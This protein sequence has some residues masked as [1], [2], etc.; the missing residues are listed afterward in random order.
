MKIDPRKTG[1]AK[2]IPLRQRVLQI[3]DTLE[4]TGTAQQLFLLARG[5]PQDEFEVHVCVLSHS[6]PLGSE[7]A[8]AGIPV[9]TIGRRWPADPATIWRLTRL[10]KAI[11]PDTIYAWQ[12]MGRA[13]AT[14]AARYCRVRM[15]AVWR[16]AQLRSSLQQREIDGAVGRQAS[17]VVATCS[18]VRDYCIQQ[19]I[20]AEKIRVIPG[21]VR[22]PLPPVATRG[23][24]LNRLGLSE[25]VALI[26]WASRLEA[27]RGGKDAIWAADLLKVIRDDAHL[28]IFGAGPHRDRLIRFRDQV[29]IADKVHFLGARADLDE[30]LPHFDQFWSTRRLPGMPQGIL[31]A[32]AAGTPVV[33]TDVPGTRDLIEHQVSGYLFAP[34]HRAGLA[35]WAEYLLNHRD[36]AKQISAAGRQRVANE[37]CAEKMIEAWRKL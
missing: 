26:G 35:R 7:L 6:G 3:I 20:A 27:E 10:V 12:T 5:L 9:Q 32:M 18:A 17:T 2:V 22:K 24:I 29:E 31:E 15:V 13:Y 8:Q 1:F 25:S 19:G 21:G 34:G 11:R 23:Q 33:A 16:E 37:F 14:I 28:L 4:R 30:F 36:T